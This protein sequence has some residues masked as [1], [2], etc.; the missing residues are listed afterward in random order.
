M[1][2]GSHSFISSVLTGVCQTLVNRFRNAYM[3]AGYLASPQGHINISTGDVI[4]RCC[5]G[6]LAYEMLTAIVATAAAAANYC[7]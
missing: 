3:N 6:G 7:R 4:Q 2:E 1:K 5:G